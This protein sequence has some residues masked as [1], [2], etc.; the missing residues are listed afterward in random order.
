MRAAARRLVA[1]LRLG[2][3]RRWAVLAR[4]GR[5]DARRTMRASL[6]TGGDPI[7]LRFRG[8]P[9]RNPRFALLVDGSR[10]MSD[11]TEAFIA[12][13]RALCSQTARA[14]AFFFS[15]ELSDVTRALRARERSEAQSGELANLGEAWGGGTRIGASLET[16]VTTH[17]A[18]LLSPE[19]LVIIFS[20]GLD[21]GDVRRL[22]SAMREID[23]RSAG[24]VWLN[25]HAATPG[26]APTAR[27]MRA[28]LPYV[29]LFAAAPDAKAFDELAARIGRE[30][31]LRGKRG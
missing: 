23:R 22:E 19:T 5:F 2:R 28:A 3:S 27:G 9:L 31:R 26:Y 30:P 7:D 12:F 6:Q 25:P 20:D 21:V 10:S 15:T 17:G 4:G 29:T 11:R 1:G 8:H 18:R 24:I 14:G 13:A 16:F